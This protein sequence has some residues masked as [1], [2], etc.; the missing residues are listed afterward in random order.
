MGP[1]HRARVRI[2]TGL[3]AQERKPAIFFLLPHAS[4]RVLTGKCPGRST[5]HSTSIVF[6][7]RRGYRLNASCYDSDLCTG[8]SGEWLKAGETEQAGQELP[9]IPCPGGRGAQGIGSGTGNTEPTGRQ[10]FGS[11]NGG[12]VLEQVRKAIGRDEPRSA[13]NDRVLAWGADR[14][15]CGRF[16]RH[17]PGKHFLQWVLDCGVK[18]REWKPFAGKGPGYTPTPGQ[19]RST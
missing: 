12:P 14:E 13:G 7:G 19:R 4:S 5:S 15:A 16:S 8:S 10:S 17:P 18:D 11:R 6:D 2:E 9:A 3:H 1:S